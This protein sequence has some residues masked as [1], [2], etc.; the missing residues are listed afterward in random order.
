MINAFKL[1]LAN[2]SYGIADI[3]EA[4]TYFNYAD[5][6]FFLLDN[7]Y[8]RDPNKLISDNKTQLGKK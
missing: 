8:Y 4:I 6:N 3:R 7:H 1:F 5:C 2:P